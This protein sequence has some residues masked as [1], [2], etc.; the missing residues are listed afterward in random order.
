MLG[1]LNL[2]PWAAT[3]RSG[4]GLSN[5]IKDSLVWWLGKPVADAKYTNQVGDQDRVAAGG[6][7]YPGRALAFDG[8]DQEAYI[9]DNSDLDINQA[10][11]DFCI[12]ANFKASSTDASQYVLGK[13][14]NQSI[15]GRY[16]FY[17]TAANVVYGLFQTDSETVT[18]DMGIDGDTD[19]EFHLFTVRVDLS[20]KKIYFYTDEVLQNV[21]GT[22]YSGNFS[23]LS[24]S[25]K[26]R[27][28]AGNDDSPIGDPVLY[29]E[30]E[31]RDV[32]IY[33]K[34]ITSAAN[35]ASLQK[36]E[37]LGGDVAWWFCEGT[38]L[39]EVLDASGNGYHMTAA[40]FDS[41]S[42][43]EGNWQSLMNKYGYAIDV[44]GAEI[45]GDVDFDGLAWWSLLGNWAIAGG[46][47]ST[48]N[49]TNITY[50]ADVLTLGRKYSF[51]AE[52]KTVSAGDWRIGCGNGL[53][54][55]AIDSVGITEVTLVCTN[56]EYVY[57]DGLTS[58]TGEIES[59]SSK[60]FYDTAIPP[61]M[62]T[63]VDGVPTHD[64]FGNVLTFAG[65]AQYKAVARDRSVFIGDN[66]ATFHPSV[67]IPIAPLSDTFEIEFGVHLGVRDNEYM[68][69]TYQAEGGSVSR[70][71]FNN[72]ALYFIDSDNNIIS[73]WT[74]MKAAITDNAYNVF[75]F[76]GDGSAVTGYLNGV[77]YETNSMV[78]FTGNMN[79]NP[80]SANSI[81][82]NG[83]HQGLINWASAQ[84]AK[85]TV[86]GVLQ[87]NWQ[88]VEGRGD[89]VHDVSG[90]GN[91]LTGVNIDNNNWGV[92]DTPIEDYLAEYGGN[93]VG[94][95]NGIDDILTFDSIVSG[96]ELEFYC[97]VINYTFTSN[98]ALFSKASTDFITFTNDTALTIRVASATNMVFVIQNISELIR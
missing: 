85:V 62:S 8:V 82:S 51:V 54:S 86:N 96:K 53:Y 94:T 98:D 39:L 28:G 20:G 73:G 61:D 88:F 32:R 27:I 74:N 48:S 64:I 71:G 63:A 69:F 16:G 29:T 42:F 65:Q 49:E 19:T 14:I 33:H 68:M 41:T 4:L 2:L 3:M 60:P 13:M 78:G 35:L 56:N 31:I 26:F 87:A 18:Q 30:T 67:L 24:N 36:G 89:T 55:S 47:L 57:I 17:L 83:S 95:F 84:F 25:Y 44:T 21:G 50:K 7:V 46:V 23:A 12:S 38:D 81:M 6:V 9:S 10:S 80:G 37:A 93:F 92:I 34:D 22:S 77:E 59:F 76:V 58:F 91:H 43:V 11:T 15:D 66:V 79:I 70:I 75:K 5:D 52:T 1:N 97:K 40:N 72:A 90:N 45:I